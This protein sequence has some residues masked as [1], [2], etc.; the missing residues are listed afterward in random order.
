MQNLHVSRSLWID[1]FC[2]P[3]GHSWSGR[4]LLIVTQALITSWLDYCN[5]L[6]KKAALENYPEIIIAPECNDKSFGLPMICHVHWI[7]VLLQV[8]KEVLVIIFKILHELRPGYWPEWLSLKIST[9]FTKSDTVGILHALSLKCCHLTRPSQHTFSVAVPALCNILP[10]DSTDY[11]LFG[12]PKSPEVLDFP[13]RIRV[14]GPCWI[15]GMC[16]WKA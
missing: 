12:L 9:Y 6:Y 2:V 1:S 14:V 5:M 11:Y 4:S 13:T 3:I 8:K 10:Q 7:S 16:V 15:W